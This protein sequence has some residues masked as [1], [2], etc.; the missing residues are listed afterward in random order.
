[1]DQWSTDLQGALEF[2]KAY[3]L[4]IDTLFDGDRYNRLYTDKL[5]QLFVYCSVY[6][7][8]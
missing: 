4:S 1:M 8:F 6:T 5:E 2:Y 7:R 3:Q